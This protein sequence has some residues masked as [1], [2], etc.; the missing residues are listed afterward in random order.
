[1]DTRGHGASDVAHGDARIEDLAR[2]VLRVV[3]GLQ[4][5]RFAYC[6]LSFGAMV[7]QWLGIHASARL[8][9]L[10]L[11]NAAAHL[12]SHE[13]WTQRMALARREGMVALVDAVMPRFVSIAV[14]TLV[15]GG[16]DTLAARRT[17]PL[18]CSSPWPA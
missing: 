2:D 18:S 17:W 15:I 16:T 6:G 3:E 8:D 1:M 7:G 9:K 5:D 13:S 12:P 11:S 14:P 4:V 10:V